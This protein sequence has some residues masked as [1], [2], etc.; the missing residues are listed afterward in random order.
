MYSNVF[1]SLEEYIGDAESGQ[2]WPMLPVFG[3]KQGDNAFA[4]IV[5]Q[6]QADTTLCFAPSGLV[7]DASRVYPIFNYRYGLDHPG[8]GRGADRPV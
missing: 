3:V 6:G 1:T 8:G 4:G 7:F 2:K 5:T